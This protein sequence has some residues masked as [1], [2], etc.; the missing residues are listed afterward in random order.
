MF[1]P[2]ENYLGDGVDAVKDSKRAVRQDINGQV[3]V[4]YA[5]RTKRNGVLGMPLIMIR[6][7][8]RDAATT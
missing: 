6:L 5:L 1:D 4:S 8:C 3:G 2:G 7:L